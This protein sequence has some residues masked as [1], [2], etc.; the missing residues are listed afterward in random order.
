[1]II[2][3]IFDN[4]YDVD[5]NFFVQKCRDHIAFLKYLPERN[6]KKL[7]YG[8]SQIFY[9]YDDI[10]FDYGDYC[11]CIYIVLSGMISI[12]LVHKKKDIT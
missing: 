4:P 1:M 12:E 3:K 6:L 11:Q 7:Y 8:C 2:D 5:R 10:L 9:D